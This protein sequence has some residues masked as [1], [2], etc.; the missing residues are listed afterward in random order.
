MMAQV[1]SRKSIRNISY[2]SLILRLFWTNL[3]ICELEFWKYLFLKLS[4]KKK[5]ISSN[6]DSLVIALYLRAEKV[7]LI[8]IYYKNYCDTLEVNNYDTNTAV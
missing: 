3:R 1:Y 5:T 4:S 2:S 8:S 6:I 7:S